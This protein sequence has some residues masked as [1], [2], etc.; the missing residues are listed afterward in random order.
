MSNAL[1][2]K[3]SLMQCCNISC[4][5]L[6]MN[7]RSEFHVFYLD[8]FAFKFVKLPGG[9][10]NILE[11]FVRFGIISAKMIRKEIFSNYLQ[12]SDPMGRY[13]VSPIVEVS[14]RSSEIF[15]QVPVKILKKKKIVTLLLVQFFF[16]FQFY[17]KH[18]TVLYRF[19]TQ[20]SLRS[21]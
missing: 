19:K 12:I 11:P 18:S 20:N 5:D 3:L 4:P 6:E 15:L 2:E 21:F 16:S 7:E 1:W 10:P 17:R 8:D 13:Q 9:F 14:S